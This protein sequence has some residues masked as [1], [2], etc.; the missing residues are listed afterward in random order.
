M[1]LFKPEFGWERT[2]PM[3]MR[4]LQ[5]E[6]R[7]LLIHNTTFDGHQR[8]VDSDEVVLAVLFQVHGIKVKFDDVVGIRPQP[9]LHEGVGGVGIVGEAWRLDLSDVVRPRMLGK[10]KKAFGRINNDKI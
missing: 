2:F 4:L 3:Q 6:T 10:L 9:P 8:V 5:L 7:D 1:L